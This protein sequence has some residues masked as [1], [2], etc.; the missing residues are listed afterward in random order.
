MPRIPLPASLA[1]PGGAAPAPGRPLLRFALLPVDWS[2]FRAVLRETIDALLR[3]EDL[4]PAD[5]AFLTTIARDGNRLPA[6]IRAWFRDRIERLGPE[7]DAPSSPELARIADASL[8]SVLEL[9]LRP[10][11]IRCADAAAPALALDAWRCGSCP[12]C[13][14]EPEM[15]ILSASGERL[16]ACGR[17]TLRWPFPE[18][19]CPFC[20]AGAAGRLRTF[21]NADRTYRLSACETCRRYLKVYDERFGDRPAMPSVDTIATLPLDAVAI[22]RGFGAGS[23][24]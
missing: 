4:E 10:F 15:G 22:Q 20:E 16:L 12:L 7:G 14:G 13:G 6:F 23:A 21:A 11:L 1:A 2:E 5:A 3:S 17:C 18:D 19:W 8:D 9:A 24:T